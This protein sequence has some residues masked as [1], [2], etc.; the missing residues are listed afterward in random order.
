MK[1][2]EDIP[3]SN[4]MKVLRNVMKLESGLMQNIILRAITEDY[5]SKVIQG[6]EKNR[7]CALGT[8]GIGKTSSTC[9][10]I[11][12]LLLQKK[13]VAYHVRSEKL[14]HWVYIFTPTDIATTFKVEIIHEKVFQTW[15]ID[16]PNTFYVVDPGQT[17]DNC[18]LA[19]DFTGKVI[20]VASPDERHWGGSDFFKGDNGIGYFLIYP[21]WTLNELIYASPYISST[22]NEK[23]IESRY[24]KVGGVPRHIFSDEYSYTDTLQRQVQ[25]VY[26]LTNHQVDIIADGNWESLLTFC[27]N[28]QMS[29]LMA[30]IDSGQEYTTISVQPVSGHIV[31]LI[32][33][34]FDKCL[35]DKMLYLGVDKCAIGWKL[36]EEYCHNQMTRE[37]HIKFYDYKYCNNAMDFVHG[38]KPL[39]LGGCKEIKGTRQSL[40][41]LAK[42]EEKVLFYPLD[43][44]HQSIDFAYYDGGIVHGFQVTLTKGHS[45]NAKHMIEYVNEAG[46]TDKFHMHYIVFV[47][48]FSAFKLKL[49]HMEELLKK[50]NEN[51]TINILHMSGPSNV[52]RGT[53]RN[54]K[55]MTSFVEQ[56]VVDLV[57]ADKTTYTIRNCISLKMGKIRNETIE[58]GGCIKIEIVDNL[59]EAVMKPPMV[60]YIQS[61][62]GTD[63]FDFMYQNG[64]DY[65]IFKCT[66]RKSAYKVSPAKINKLVLIVMRTKGN[67]LLEEIQFSTEKQKM[68]ICNE[69]LSIAPKI[70]IYYVVPKKNYD[71]FETNPLDSN[72]S[73]KIEFLQQNKDKQ[74]TPLCLCWNKIV[75]INVLG[76]DD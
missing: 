75:S 43:T 47:T 21:I 46:G 13:T 16:T 31:R 56:L 64:N 65:F 20:I 61:S 68:E 45:F 57:Y 32:L 1:E 58:I 37:E 28:P 34:N 69:R 49:L 6:T 8:P 12:L 3:N 2:Y 70:Y 18:N 67:T 54:T 74:N 19:D 72:E 76:V 44:S 15:M 52:T 22:I 48:K 27:S 36:F 38:I 30:Y 17:K 7:I 41:S 71:K 24:T 42:E 40:I 33:K 4:G 55:K 29:V 9:I 63:Y 14:H 59:V 50:D 10:L 25:G 26:D 11:R 39:I 73:A 62:I 51:M 66:A 60:L 35:W 53:W 5:W 23:E